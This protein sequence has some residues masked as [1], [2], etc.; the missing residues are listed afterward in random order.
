MK[1]YWGVVVILFLLFAVRV[2]AQSDCDY[3]LSF[4]NV[5]FSRTQID[6]GY[7]VSGFSEYGYYLDICGVYTGNTT[8]SIY[9]ELSDDSGVYWSVYGTIIWNKAMTNAYI[10]ASYLDETYSTYLDGTIKLSRRRYKISA[11]GGDNDSVSYITIFNNINGTGDLLDNGV[12][13]LGQG[14]RTKFKNLDKSKLFGLK[15]KL[16]TQTQPGQ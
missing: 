16:Q 11:K 10:Q 9:A 14:G 4:E 15:K 12:S 2:Y 5:S 1:R 8:D 6:D 7:F 13:S 3:V